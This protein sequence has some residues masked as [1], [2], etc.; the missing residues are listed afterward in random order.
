MM[1]NIIRHDCVPEVND[2]LPFFVVRK[3]RSCNFTKNDPIDLPPIYKKDLT[4]SFW[5][6][7]IGAEHL[8]YCIVT[9]LLAPPRQNK[10]YD[11]I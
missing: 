11:F 6:C 4:S 9:L 5:H 1:T 3:N 2:R 8:W 7:I 10:D